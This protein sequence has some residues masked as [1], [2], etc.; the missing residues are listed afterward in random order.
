MKGL[1][2]PH[3][4]SSGQ[5]NNGGRSIIRNSP[6]EHIKKKDPFNSLLFYG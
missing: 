1:E 2:M 4:F 5:L 3:W 6:L